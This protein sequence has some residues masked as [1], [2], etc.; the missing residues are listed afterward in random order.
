[1]PNGSAA[2]WTI[3]V[4]RSTASSSDRRV[5]SGRPGGCSG[6]ARH[7]TASA[8]L[9]AAGGQG[10]RAPGGGAGG[11][12]PGGA[13][14]DDERELAQLIG[15]QALDDGEPGGVELVCRRR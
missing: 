11:G 1:M 15:A 3:S 13:A 12:S 6:K 2:P 10:A 14:A 9:S 7:R 5:F 8:P 4:G